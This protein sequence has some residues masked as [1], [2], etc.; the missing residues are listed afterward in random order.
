MN[1]EIKIYYKY[2]YTLGEDSVNIEGFEDW[3]EHVINIVDVRIN[4][5]GVS[6][7]FMCSDNADNKELFMK[8]ISKILSN[9]MDATCRAYELASGRFYQFNE[10]WKEQDKKDEN[11]SFN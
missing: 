4:R 10:F 2:Q 3:D 7:F 5:L 8:G 9:D 1:E 11:N 6:R